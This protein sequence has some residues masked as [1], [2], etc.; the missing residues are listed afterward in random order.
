M[1]PINQNIYYRENWNLISPRRWELFGIK[2][3]VGF[4]LGLWRKLRIPEAHNSGKLINETLK[5]ETNS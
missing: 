5:D 2:Y 1:K 4:R 3:N